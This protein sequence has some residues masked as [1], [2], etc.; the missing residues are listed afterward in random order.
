MDWKLAISASP[1]SRSGQSSQRSGEKVKSLKETRAADNEFYFNQIVG[2]FNGS[3]SSSNTG[4]VPTN[5]QVMIVLVGIPGSGKS[6]MAAKIL[7][8]SSS[9]GTTPEEE[10]S[11]RWAIA[12][13]DT[14]KSRSRVEQYTVEQ[15]DLGRSVLVDRCVAPA[16]LS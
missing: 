10:G 16:L 15:L 11:G 3:N 8:M 5:N 6:T 1:G 14:L 13:Q 9:S 7:S 4:S 12:N 2:L